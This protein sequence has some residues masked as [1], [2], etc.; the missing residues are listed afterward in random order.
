MF[1]PFAKHAPRLH[2]THLED[3]VRAPYIFMRW[4]VPSMV[5]GALRDLFVFLGVGLMHVLGRL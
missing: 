2:K 5:W 4:K 3:P 1:A